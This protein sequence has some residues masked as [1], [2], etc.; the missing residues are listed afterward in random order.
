M[1]RELG[2]APEEPVVMMISVLRLEKGHDLAIEAVR[3]LARFRPNLRLVIVGD[4]PVRGRLE[5]QAG[6]LGGTVLFTG[7]RDDVMELLDAADILLH[8]SR[9]DAFPG[10]VVEALAARVPVVASAVGGIPEI[11]A[12]GVGGV[13]VQPRCSPQALADV[14][15]QLLSDTDRQH[16]LATAGRERFERDFTAR[17]WAL[18]MRSVYEQAIAS[19]P[20]GSRVEQSLGGRHHHH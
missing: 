17:Q 15:E 12:D 2:L 13:L 4:G 18:R 9:I 7:H 3:T 6:A 10:S 11:I 19:E 16:A 5:A 14:L 1:R 20:L 8:P